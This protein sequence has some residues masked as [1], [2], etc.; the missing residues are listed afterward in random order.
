MIS[1]LDILVGL[2]SWLVALV[3]LTLEIMSNFKNGHVKN[4]YEIELWIVPVLWTALVIAMV[5]LRRRP[6]RK[7][8]W[9]WLSFPFAFL[10]WIGGIFMIMIWSYGSFAP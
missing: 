1:R 5:A 7:L 9:V 3:P 8:W 4:S 10:F 6:L 2:L